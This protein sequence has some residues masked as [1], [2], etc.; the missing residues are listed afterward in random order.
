[1][2]NLHINIRGGHGTG[3]T[4]ISHKLLEDHAH[5]SLLEPEWIQGKHFALPN[6]FR[7]PGNPSVHVVGRYK[8]GMDGIFPQTIVEEML[9]YWA[10]QGHVIWENVMVSANIGRW[11]V[12]ANELK[13]SGVHPIWMFMDTPLELCI[14]RV[15]A[16]RR[17]ASEKGF[18]HRQA[19]TDV[20]LDVLA[21]HWRRVRRSAV[22][23]IRQGIDVRW[24]DHT[25]SYEQVHDVL[26]SEGGWNPQEK[27]SHMVPPLLPWNPTEE[28]ADYLLKT[29]ILPWEP[30]DTVTK[31]AYTPKPKI[32]GTP[33]VEFGVKVK[34]WGGESYDEF[35][36][37]VREW[38]ETQSARASD[39]ITKETN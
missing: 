5:D 15:F 34:K 6:C 11:A 39:T 31:V 17:A 19:D 4:Y 24:I 20:K 18:N 30:A 33:G 29:A 9:H 27:L 23:A 37:T 14:E 26:V 38:N 25:R 7:M 36:V 1:M 12:L 32:K 8:S 2:S 22:R 21:G 13:A 28:E 3:K 16:R 35:G 10:P